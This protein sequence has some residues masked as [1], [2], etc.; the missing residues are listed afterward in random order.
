MNINKMNGN[1]TIKMAKDLKGLE[2]VTTKDA[3]GNT[4]VMNGVGLLAP[5]M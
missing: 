3:A 1:I 2:S 5:C 4:T